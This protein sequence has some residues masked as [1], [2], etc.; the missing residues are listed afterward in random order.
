MYSNSWS[1]GPLCVRLCVC[2][3]LVKYPCWVSMVTVTFFCRHTQTSWF[4]KVEGLIR[5]LVEDKLLF[6]RG[7]EMQAMGIHS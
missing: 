3:F 6:P 2:D 7:S 4:M 1:D 5:S